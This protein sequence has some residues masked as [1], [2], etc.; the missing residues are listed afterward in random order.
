MNAG[1]TKKDLAHINNELEKWSG[2]D[3]RIEHI[4]DKGLIALQGP[5]AGRI[6][7]KH[8]KENLSKFYF[9]Q[10]GHFTIPKVNEKILLRRSG[11]TGEDGFKLSISNKNLE[12]VYDILL[13][14]P[15]VKP[16]GLGARDTLRLEAGM[17]LYGQ[18]INETTSPIEAGLTWAIG[19]WRR[20]ISCL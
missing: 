1:T 15:D 18:E 14:D 12:K 7:Q 5:L 17:C 9:M 3:V 8:I 10:I 11:Y 20:R 16:A 19:K 13:H 4:Q 2:K 6:L